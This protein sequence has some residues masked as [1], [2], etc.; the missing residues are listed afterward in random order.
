LAISREHSF[1]DLLFGF[2]FHAKL[3]GVDVGDGSAHA[4]V[5]LAA[6]ERFLH[7]LP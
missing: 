1:P 3:A 2:D 7:A 5:G 4:V 6:I